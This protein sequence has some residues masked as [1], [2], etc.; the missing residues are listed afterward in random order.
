MT[1]NANLRPGTLIEYKSAHSTEKAWVLDEPT[2]EGVVSEGMVRI[3]VKGETG[4]NIDKE[5]DIHVKAR[6]RAKILEDGPID[7]AAEIEKMSPRKKRVNV[8]TLKSDIP[9]HDA[10]EYREPNTGRIATS[11]AE[12]TH[13]KSKAGRAACRKARAAANA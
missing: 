5:F 9:V 13:E 1:T 7:E 8:Q 12:C 3:R 2:A 11:H 10:G 6:G 4:I